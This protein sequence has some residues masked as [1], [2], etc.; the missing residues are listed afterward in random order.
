MALVAIHTVVHIPA[1]IRMLE[2]ACVPAAM[3]LRA[4][5][6]L[7]VARIC[8]AGCANSIR[9]TVIYVEPRVVEYGAGPCGGRMARVASG[10]EPSRFVVRIGRVVV[11]RLVAAHACGRQRRVVVID[12]AHHASHGRCGM[13]S[14]KREGRV[15]VIK[16]RA[17]PVGG[18]MADIAGR[19]EAGGRVGRRI[20]VVV[21][22]LMA[23]NAGRVSSSQS[24]VP[25]H[26]ALSA[27][28]R[29]VEA[30]ERKPGG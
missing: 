5:K 11:I 22:G 3:A 29:E 18:A 8:V 2:I 25:V 19:R 23:R 24:V 14:S 12:V 30:R 17:R 28:H 13:E 6:H 15:V 21:V 1:D 7:V 27:G 16:Y 20:G 4:L 10:R 9:V 26:V